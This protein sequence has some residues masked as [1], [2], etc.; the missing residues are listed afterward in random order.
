MFIKYK[1]KTIEQHYAAIRRMFDNWGATVLGITV[2]YDDSCDPGTAFVVTL[3]G[4]KSEINKHFV[5]QVLI[6]YAYR[7]EWAE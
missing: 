6:H 3:Q 4:R 5:E 2:E 7:I 1:P